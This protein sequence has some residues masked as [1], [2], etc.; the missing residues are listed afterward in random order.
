MSIHFASILQNMQNILWVHSSSVVGSVSV[1]LVCVTMT[2]LSKID[3]LIP[4]V[5]EIIGFLGPNLYPNDLTQCPPPSRLACKAMEICWREREKH[6]AITF[7]I[8]KG[9]GFEFG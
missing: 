4:L 6:S 5:Q 3:R 8:N 7:C 9:L 1:K 2:N